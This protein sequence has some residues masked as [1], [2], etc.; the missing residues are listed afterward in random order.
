MQAGSPSSAASKAMRRRH[1]LGVVEAVLA[2]RVE[3]AHKGAHLPLPTQ[4]LRQA[5]TSSCQVSKSSRQIITASNH[6]CVI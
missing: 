6:E 3:G 5:E 1:T 4:T 2:A